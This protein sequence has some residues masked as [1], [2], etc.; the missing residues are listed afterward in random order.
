MF[1]F[2]SGQLFRR[3]DPPSRKTETETR[4]I[5]ILSNKYWEDH[6]RRLREDQERTRLELEA[7]YAATRLLNP[8]TQTFVFPD[9]EEKKTVYVGSRLFL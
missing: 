7:R 4:D 5:N 1:P 9:I 3:N 8:V 6:D 2:Y